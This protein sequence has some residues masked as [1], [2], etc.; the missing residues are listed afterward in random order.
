M[1]IRDR[2]AHTLEEALTGLSLA[3]DDC[4]IIGSSALILSGIDL[5]TT[6]DIDLLVS[7][8]AARMI[9]K[10]WKEK[11]IGHSIPG[12]SNLFRSHL[13]RYRFPLMDIEALEGLE[14]NKSNR[15]ERLIINN[16]I[17]IEIADSTINI[18]TLTEQIRILTL[19]GRQKD[20]EKLP[21]IEQ[22]LNNQP[23]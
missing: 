14:V 9:R 10:E 3:N 5:Q 16:F 13:T 6:S 19:F 22:F 15:W 21:L 1:T 20:L 12:D 18:P 8:K 2:I 23:S 11:E 7:S 17:K 4:F